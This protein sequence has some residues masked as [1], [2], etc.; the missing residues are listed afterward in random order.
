MNRLRAAAT[1]AWRL[2]KLLGEL[3]PTEAKYSRLIASDGNGYLLLE[4]LPGN[5]LLLQAG[6]VQ[7]NTGS[8]HQLVAG[9]QGQGARP[10]Q[11]LASIADAQ[12]TD[13]RRSLTLRLRTNALGPADLQ[14]LAM[15]LLANFTTPDPTGPRRGR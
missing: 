1:E 5:R 13:R 8:I 11:P 15:L 3:T 6:H 10:S 7:F 4:R 12:V 9:T 2:W 14:N